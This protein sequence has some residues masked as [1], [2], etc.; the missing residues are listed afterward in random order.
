MIKL[1]S[2]GKTLVVLL[3]RSHCNINKVD[4]HD[5]HYS[6]YSPT[7]LNQDAET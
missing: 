6:H 7:I 4:Y 2:F 3:D 1:I 5:G